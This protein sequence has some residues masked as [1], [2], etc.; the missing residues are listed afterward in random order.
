[1]ST[2]ENKAIVRR[3]YEEVLNKRSFDAADD[4]ISANYDSHRH[5]I[6]Q[7][8][9]G[10]KGLKQAWTMA[11]T[12]FPDL[13]FTVEDM[14]AEGDKVAVRLSHGGTHQGV[15]M[16]VAPTGKEARWTGNSIFRIADGKIVEG[17]VEGDHLGLMQ[18][19]GAIPAPG[20]AG[21]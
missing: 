8:A 12:G 15:F 20:Q 16:G 9:P 18:Q 5:P 13:Q 21:S 17:W 4:I 1:M 10:L 7:Q 6:P 19:L 14:I 11:L 3:I 2:E